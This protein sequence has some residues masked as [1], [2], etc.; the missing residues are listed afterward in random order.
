MYGKTKVEKGHEMKW[1]QF[2]NKI[3]NC[4]CGED[5]VTLVGK[6]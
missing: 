5:Y 4:N 1:Q 2:S 6:Y 3:I